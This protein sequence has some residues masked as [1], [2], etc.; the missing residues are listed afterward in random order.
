MIKFSAT[1]PQVRKQAIDQGLSML[2]W[3]NDPVLK[4]YGLQIN[5]SMLQTK[6]RLLDPPTVGYAG[7][8]SA[9]PGYAGRWDLRGKTFLKPNPSELAYW[10]VCVIGPGQDRRG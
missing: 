10:G 5:A 6:A 2:D 1:R 9:Q 3:A 4:N 7:G 8:G